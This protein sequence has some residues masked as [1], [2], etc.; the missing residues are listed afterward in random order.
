MANP[1]GTGFMKLSNSSFRP[2]NM[3]R[4]LIFFILSVM[5][6]GGIS[7]HFY[8]L[9]ITEWLP[10]IPLCAFK[11]ITTM[12]CPG[13]GMT[14]AVLN[15]G[16]LNFA[17]ALEYN[18]FSLPLLLVMVIFLGFGKFPLWFRPKYLAKVALLGVI[19]FWLFRLHLLI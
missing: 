19:L 4:I 3:L 9:D 10:E 16:Q 12:D 8:E 6:L 7:Y 15:I 14:R 2:S 18:P 13:C 11:A 5:I 1:N 17:N